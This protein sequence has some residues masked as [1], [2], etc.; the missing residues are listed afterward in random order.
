LRGRD[1]GGDVLVE[2]QVLR[3]EV[4]G[5]ALVGLD[6]GGPDHLAPFLGFLRDKLT[7]VSG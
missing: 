4:L 1:G 6:I 5:G 3:L 7:E 2:Q